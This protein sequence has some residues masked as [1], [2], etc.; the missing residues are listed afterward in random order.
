MRIIIALALSVTA[1]LAQP[2]LC[3]S[4]IEENGFYLA[5]TGQALDRNCKPT[6][7]SFTKTVLFSFGWSQDKT[8]VIDLSNW[9]NASKES[10]AKAAAY[11]EKI[12]PASAPVVVEWNFPGCFLGGLWPTSSICYSK[13]V[14]LI[15]L[16]PKWRSATQQWTENGYPLI[17]GLV[18]NTLMRNGEGGALPIL[19]SEVDRARN[20]IRP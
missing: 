19:A 16:F 12:A 1:A 7:W 9:L 3:D 15:V 5:P 20:A 11:I 14:T 2:V 6:G 18:A 17:A 10:A 8:K 13:P 4:Q